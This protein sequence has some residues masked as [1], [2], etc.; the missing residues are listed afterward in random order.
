MC[1]S[2]VANARFSDARL[3]MARSSMPVGNKVRSTGQADLLV[4]I[5]YSMAFNGQAQCPKGC[6]IFKANTHATGF[7]SSLDCVTKPIRRATPP[8][9]ATVVRNPSRYRI[10]LNGVFPASQCQVPSV[11]F[12]P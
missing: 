9:I 5:M 7:V 4:S 3:C 10:R 11:Y 8:A 1:N 12:T 2:G 6:L